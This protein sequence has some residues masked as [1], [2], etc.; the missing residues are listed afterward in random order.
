MTIYF[1]ALVYFKYNYY[2]ISVPTVVIYYILVAITNKIT[3]RIIV[4]LYY[5]C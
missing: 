4:Q 3:E 5:G 2:F 1:K